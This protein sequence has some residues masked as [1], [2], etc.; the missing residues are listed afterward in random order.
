MLA[1]GTAK[2]RS[3][4]SIFYSFHG[5]VFYI[6]FFFNAENKLLPLLGEMAC[7]EKMEGCLS[8]RWIQFTPFSGL[9]KRMAKSRR[10]PEPP[11]VLLLRGPPWSCP[12][13]DR[14]LLI[15]RPSTPH[16]HLQATSEV[17]KGYGTLYSS[18]SGEKSTNGCLSSPWVSAQRAPKC[19]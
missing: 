1:E 19:S 9:I 10:R 8:A 11:G 6:F 18:A 3:Q 12:K 7:A 13:G 4:V 17:A 16:S 5:F 14:A 15:G 2:G